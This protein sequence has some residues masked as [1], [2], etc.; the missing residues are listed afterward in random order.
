[1]KKRSFA[2]ICLVFV[3]VFSTMAVSAFAAD[4][5]VAPDPA[6][7]DQKSNIRAGFHRKSETDIAGAAVAGVADQDPAV[8]FNG[9]QAQPQI[10]HAIGA[11][12]IDRHDA[13]SLKLERRRGRCDPERWPR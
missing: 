9:V 1:M 7:S 11:V 5:T 6:V 13:A 4:K 10:R 8:G 12:D 2:A 3:L